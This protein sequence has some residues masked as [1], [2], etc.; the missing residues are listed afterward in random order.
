MNDPA[1]GEL[2]RHK[3]GRSYVVLHITN[4]AHVRED[5]PPDV[6]YATSFERG[7]SGLCSFGSD[8][9]SYRPDKIWSRPLSD[10]HRSFT[11]D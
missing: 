1:R 2:W 9:P 11:K 6:V 4:T 10:W 3:N 7:E 5:H 8:L